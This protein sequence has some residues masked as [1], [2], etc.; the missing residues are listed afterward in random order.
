MIKKDKDNAYWEHHNEDSN[1]DKDKAK[2]YNP[3][4]D[5]QPQSQASKKCQRSWQGDHLA[6]E[7]NATKV[8]K[9][10]KD[11]NKAKILSYIKCYTYK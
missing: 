2:S 6:T 11:K 5:N 8:A 7:V 3:F 4:F 1:R 9:K 10:N